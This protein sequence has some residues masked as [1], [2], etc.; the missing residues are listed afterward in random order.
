[1][2]ECSNV[3]IIERVVR[4]VRGPYADVKLPCWLGDTFPARLIVF[5]PSGSG[6]SSFIDVVTSTDT[7]AEERIPTDII[8]SQDP[9]EAYIYPKISAIA[10]QAELFGDEQDRSQIAKVEQSKVPKI[11]AIFDDPRDDSESISLINR[12]FKRGRHDGISPVLVMHSA[13]QLDRLKMA[14]QQATV[15][16]STSAGAK[17]MAENIKAWGNRIGCPDIKYEVTKFTAAPACDEKYTYLLFIRTSDGL[18]RTH[19]V[20][21]T[22]KPIG[23]SY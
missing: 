17:L 9:N 15:F 4:E 11:T 5:G 14:V 21:I 8:F 10:E 3:T 2:A 6:K 19:Y 22:T 16:V 13:S 7:A 18:C 20:Q 12:V 23:R 1:M